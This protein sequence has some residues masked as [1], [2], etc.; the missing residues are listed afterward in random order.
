ML[1]MCNGL[2]P[3]QVSSCRSV[4]RGGHIDMCA[5]TGDR[6]ALRPSRPKGANPNPERDEVRHAEVNSRRGV[7][8]L[9]PLHRR[10]QV[11]LCKLLRSEPPQSAVAEARSR[12]G[13]VL[14]YDTPFAL[15]RL[16]YST[17]ERVPQRADGSA[18]RLSAYL[19]ERTANRPQDRH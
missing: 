9:G 3:A 13:K 2:A 16:S 4:R 7:F 17:R 19:S 12:P 8:C 15:E 10:A 14:C 11:N 18:L 5:Q 6:R 1:V